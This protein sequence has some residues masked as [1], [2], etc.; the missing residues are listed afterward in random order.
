MF[1]GLQ[2][3]MDFITSKGRMKMTHIYK[4]VMIQAVAKRNGLATRDE[5][6]ADFL[7]RDVLQI[8]HYRRKVV[9][10]MPGDRLVRD[11]VL[12][13]D[14]DTYKLAS[15]FDQLKES[16]RLELIA[17]CEKRIE[18]H[19]ETWGDQFK[20][21]NDDPVPGSTRYEVLRRSGGRCE[22]CGASHEEIQID[23]DHIIPRSK[24]GTNDESN[25]QALCR[26]CNAQKLNRDDTNF[27]EVAESY[28]VRVENCVFCEQDGGV[29]I[30]AEN[31]LAIAIEDKYPV[32]SLH[33]LIIPKRHVSDYFEL[34][35][36]ERNAIDQLLQ[37]QR[38]VIQ[39]KDNTV[40]GF[41]VG[42]NIGQD[43]GQ[44]VDH[45]HVHLIPRRNGDVS[46]P[47]GGVRGVI[48]EKQKYQIN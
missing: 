43:A 41:N 14:G 35:Q 25:L 23:V 16:E 15:P 29:L 9:H 42:V 7:S 39:A 32:T 6:A 1:T 3:L 34:H 48:P 30:I 8:E 27:S 22:L 13:R 5:I 47:L 28:K 4:P 24:G 21:R 17:T 11:G 20:S 37:E 44:T 33:T 12:V 36:S 26:T 40:S 38:T 31:E 2:D 19:I 45:V 46:D 18:D 10:Q